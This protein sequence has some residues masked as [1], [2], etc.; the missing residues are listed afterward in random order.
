MINWIVK[1]FGGYTQLE[2]DLQAQ[3]IESWTRRALASETTVELVKEILAKER[4]RTDK[5]QSDLYDRLHPNQHQTPP[6]I[7]PLGNGRTSWPRIKRQLEKQNRVPDAEVS[8]E[9]IEK[10]IR[11]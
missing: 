3:L 4:E 9:E 11:G 7:K 10:G 1:F 2:Y 8:R 5:I 6:E